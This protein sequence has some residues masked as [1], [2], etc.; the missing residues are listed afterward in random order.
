MINLNEILKR[1]AN[2]ITR[3]MRRRLEIK[4]NENKYEIVYHKSAFW[5]EDKFSIKEFIKNL[6]INHWEV[7]Q[8]INGS[9]INCMGNGAGII[10]GFFPKR[11]MKK[12]LLASAKYWDNIN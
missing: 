1:K 8:V 5:W 6:Y 4:Y 10:S 9:R 11:K 12:Q 3:R 7:N 2:N